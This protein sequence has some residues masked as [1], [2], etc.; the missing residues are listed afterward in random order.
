[1]VRVVDV[2][3]CQVPYSGEEKASRICFSARRF[4]VEEVTRL[5]KI[6]LLVPRIHVVIA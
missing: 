6:V 1:M 5:G 4:Y 3:F 2:I